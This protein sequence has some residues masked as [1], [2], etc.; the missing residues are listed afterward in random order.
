MRG[1]NS[2][3]SVRTLLLRGLI[4]G[5]EDPTDKRRVR[6]AVT[7]E[8]LAH[9]G[10]S[11]LEDLPRYAELSASAGSVLKEQVMNDGGSVGVAV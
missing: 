1:V 2:S 8:A 10:L 4:E 11:R 6:Y 3:A 7:T 5:R 9:L